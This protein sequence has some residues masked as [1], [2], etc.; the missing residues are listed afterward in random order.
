MHRVE[1]RAFLLGETQINQAGLQAYLDAVGAPEWGTNAPSDGEELVEVMGRA[2]YRSFKPG[3]NANVKK[4]REGNDVYLKNITKTGH[5]SVLEHAVTNWMFYNVS[6]VF[7]HELVRHRVGTAISQE[8]LRFVRLEDLGLWLPSEVEQYPELVKL[9]EE[10]FETL[11]A[12]QVRMAELLKLND[13]KTPFPEKKKWT[14]LMR[15]AAPIGLATSI[16]FSMNFRTM[17]H[18]LVMRTSRFAEVEIRLVFQEVGRISRSR[19]PNIFLDFKEEVV[20]NLIEYTSPFVTI[21]AA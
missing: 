11:G 7:T 12:L 20:D 4:V 14:S 3:L 5:G 21:Q 6:R 19:W 13:P 18:L 2:C 1:P 8:S 15:R 10:T 16:G 17:R 9:F